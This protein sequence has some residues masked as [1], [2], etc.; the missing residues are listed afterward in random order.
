MKKTYE[1]PQIDIIILSPDDIMKQSDEIIYDPDD[2]VNI[3]DDNE[4]PPV[5]LP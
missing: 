4:G 5:L 3:R 1:T 2:D